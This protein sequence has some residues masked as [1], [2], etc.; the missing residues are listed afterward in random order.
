MKMF[1]M[2]ISSHVMNMVT[3][4]WT[5]DIMQGKVLEDSITS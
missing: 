4:I 1:F 2:V 5:A 3:N